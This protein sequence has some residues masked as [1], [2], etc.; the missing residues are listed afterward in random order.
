MGER[1][2]CDAIDLHPRYNLA[3]GQN[4]AVLPAG[5]K[6]CLGLM[7]W[8][9]AS[10]QIS[11]PIINAR[12]ESLWERPLFREKVARQRCI[13]PATGFYEWDREGQ[14]YNFG[15]TARPLFALAGL[16]GMEKGGPVFALITMAAND[17][18]SKIHHRMPL[19]LRPENEALWLDDQTISKDAILSLIETCPSEQMFSHP[20]SRKINHIGNDCP[21]CLEPVA[22][23]GVQGLL[24]IN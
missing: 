1:F 6:R 18:V 4:A 3:P 22:R 13:V 2:G 19:I 17:L 7:K 16:W 14:P 21:D 12:S 5:G 10:R 20:V 15:L 9:M 23:A 24:G 8:G 11:R